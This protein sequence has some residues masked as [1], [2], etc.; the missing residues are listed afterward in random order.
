MK[1]YKTFGTKKITRDGD[2]DG[3]A[4]R[5]T[6]RG[7]MSIWLMKT[8]A[9]LVPPIVVERVRKVTASVPLHPEKP[10]ATRNPA[11]NSRPGV[12]IKRRERERDGG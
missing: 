7:A 9:A 3:D 5:D 2:S 11:G 8:P 12:T 4:S 1:K 10:N 6:H